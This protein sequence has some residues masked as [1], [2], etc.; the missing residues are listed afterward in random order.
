MSPKKKP[1]TRSSKPT[2]GKRRHSP[3]AV[4]SPQKPIEPGLV[5]VE[6]SGES[7]DLRQGGSIYGAAMR[8][9]MSRVALAQW[10]WRRGYTGGES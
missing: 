5:S 8:L 6:R 9:G 10:P 4:V 1:A 3:D 7:P 2:H